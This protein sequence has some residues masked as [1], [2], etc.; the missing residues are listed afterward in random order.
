MEDSSQ[1]NSHPVKVLGKG[2]ERNKT[3][4]DTTNGAVADGERNAKA[5]FL[6]SFPPLP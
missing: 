1:D 5:L 2:L 3:P 4:N 6:Q